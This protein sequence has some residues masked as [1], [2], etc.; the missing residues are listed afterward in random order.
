MSDEVKGV[1]EEL[2]KCHNCHF[3]PWLSLLTYRHWHEWM[4]EWMNEWM[5]EWMS[6][7]MNAWVNE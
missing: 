1:K 7:W 5:S 3:D 2:E 6:K 4:C